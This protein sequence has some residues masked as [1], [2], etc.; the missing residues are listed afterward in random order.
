MATSTFT[1]LLNSQRPV[2]QYG[3]RVGTKRSIRCLLEQENT[4]RDHM[5]WYVTSH[6]RWMSHDVFFV[7]CFCFFLSFFFFFFFLFQCCFT[8]TE[9]IRLIRD[10]SPGRPPRLSHGSWAL[11]ARSTSKVISGRRLG[12]K[13]STRSAVG[14]RK[15]GERPHAVIRDVTC[16]LAEPWRSFIYL[17]IFV[18]F[19]CL[20]IYLFLIYFLLL[21]FSV[22][23]YVH[24]NHQAY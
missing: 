2:N 10:G 22:L 17:F 9:T 16:T 3:R 6:T 20:F 7:F 13:H 18:L 5:R 4:G 19:V 1:Q 11:N 12:T 24:R 21:S 14:A 23:F 15:H 8:S